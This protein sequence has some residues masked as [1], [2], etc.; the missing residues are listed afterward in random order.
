[1][2]FGPTYKLAS[3]R[4]GDKTTEERVKLGK[5]ASDRFRR[6]VLDGVFVRGI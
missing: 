3:W 6:P 5:P 1:M 4:I 2:P